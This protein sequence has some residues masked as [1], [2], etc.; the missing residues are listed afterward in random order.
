MSTGNSTTLS[1]RMSSPLMIIW[2]SRSVTVADRPR[3]MNVPS[4]WM[5]SKKAS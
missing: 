5:R 1:L 4:S 2:P 3:T